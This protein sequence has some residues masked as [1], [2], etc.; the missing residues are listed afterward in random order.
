MIRV[1][2]V[3]LGR[4]GLNHLRVLTSLPVEVFAADLD[5]RR[6]RAAADTGIPH[7]RLGTDP[8]VIAAQVDAVAV[9]TPAPSHFELCRVFLDMGK[10]VFVEKPMTVRS[11]DARALVDLAARRGRI[12]QVGHIFRF[13]PAS[14]WLRATIERGELGALRLLRGRFSGF[15]RVVAGTGV[16]FADAIHFVDLFN[17]ML[18]APPVRVHAHCHDFLGRGTEDECLIAMQYA[19]ENRAGTP[20]PFIWATVEAGYHCPGK[21]REVTIIGERLSVVCDYNVA[22]YK[23]KTFD[24]RHEPSGAEFVAI[25]GP[26]HQLEFSPE[27]PLL[28]EWRAFLDSIATRRRPLSDGRSAMDAV[29]VVE[30]ALE[31]ARRGSAIEL[32]R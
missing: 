19:P 20:S 25:E 32:P 15:K 29:E 26:V 4:W 16:A 30:A 17:Y 3:G 18:G 9:V 21:S 11:S 13:D 27:E 22:Q 24:N 7:E 12:L 23:V 14:R 10:D 28:I 31:S 5:E 2:L 6:L 1:L 8:R